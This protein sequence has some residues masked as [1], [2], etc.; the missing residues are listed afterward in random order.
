LAP[1]LKDRIRQVLFSMHQDPHGQQILAELMIDRFTP[2]R[3]EWYD[4][5]RNMALKIASLEK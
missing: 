1:D 5:I 4:S 3:D 2:T